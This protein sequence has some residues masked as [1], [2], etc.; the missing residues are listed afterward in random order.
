MLS[1][2]AKLPCF[3][4]GEAKITKK[5]IIT[6]FLLSNLLGLHRMKLFWGKQTL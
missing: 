6:H 4:A 3:L 5:K 2:I 1:P